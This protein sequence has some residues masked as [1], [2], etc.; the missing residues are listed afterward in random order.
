[1]HRL[2]IFVVVAVI[3]AGC[4]QSSVGPVR[5]EDLG[6]PVGFRA[7]VV[8]GSSHEELVLTST[9]AHDR[10][11]IPRQVRMLE[12]RDGATSSRYFLDGSWREIAESHT[13]EGSVSTT[14]LSAGA[15]AFYGLGFPWLAVGGTEVPFFHQGPVPV[16]FHMELDRQ[17]N[18]YHVELP[19][20]TAF[21][22]TEDRYPVGEYWYQPN[23]VLPFRAPYFQ[24]DAYLEAEALVDGHVADYSWPTINMEQ[25]GLMFP[26]SNES[27]FQHS[28]SYDDILGYLRDNFPEVADAERAGACLNDFVLQFETSRTASGLPAGILDSIVHTASIEIQRAG[29][30]LR[31][32][33]AITENGVTKPSFEGVP[34]TPLLEDS[35]IA[36]AAVAVPIA[37]A[38]NRFSNLLGV[39]AVHHYELRAMPLGPARPSDGLYQHR[40]ASQ[41]GTEIVSMTID[42]HRGWLVGAITPAESAFPRVR[43]DVSSRQ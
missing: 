1:M 4:N 21:D 19:H 20:S 3:V 13:S 26:G 7:T 34:T 5:A 29:R 27:L 43:G 22:V 33:I 41:S 2:S 36:S 23:R 39:Q 18:R 14:F 8:R 38:L 25:S 24:V 37:D 31:Y 28:F 42:A 11:G 9:T 12:V 30:D 16:I 15:P 10:E 6:S 17:G 40:L 32:D 35:C